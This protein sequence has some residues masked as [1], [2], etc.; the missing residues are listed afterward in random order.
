MWGHAPVREDTPLSRLVAIL[1]LLI[2]PLAVAT[3][4]HADPVDDSAYGTPLV[5]VSG[6]GIN[7]H[8]TTGLS[9]LKAQPG[10]T[11][12]DFAD[13]MTSA[14]HPMRTC[15][16]T[17]AAGLPIKPAAT[18]SWCWDSG[19][20]ST[21]TWIPQSLTTSGDADDEAPGGRT[22]PSSAAGTTATPANAE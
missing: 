11:Q 9:T 15:D 16:S 7:W 17:E 4:A 20:A 19:D 13:V 10:L 22:R 12:V 18:V 6:A 1:L 21:E 5:A 14:N 3:P 2:V 8:P